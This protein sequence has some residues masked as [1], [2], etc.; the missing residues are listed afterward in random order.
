VL[1]DLR[2]NVLL[3]SSLGSAFVDTYYHISPSLAEIVA[4]SPTLRYVAYCGIKLLLV[5]LGFPWPI[6]LVGFLALLAVSRLGK[7]RAGIR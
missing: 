3:Q 6:L 2:D 1:R 4:D 5:A 7:R